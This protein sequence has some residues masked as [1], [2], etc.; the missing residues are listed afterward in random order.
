MNAEMYTKKNLEIFMDL[1]HALSDENNK[2]KG[3]EKEKK[4]KYE[5]YHEGK[6]KL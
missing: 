5:K 3:D 4:E 2:I 6:E 1:K